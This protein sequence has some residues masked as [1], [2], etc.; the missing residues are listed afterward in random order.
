[1]CYQIIILLQTKIDNLTH[2][3]R[4]HFSQLHGSPSHL[5]ISIFY[6]WRTIIADC[7]ATK[8]AAMPYKIHFLKRVLSQPETWWAIT[9]LAIGTLFWLAVL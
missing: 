6:D 1:M 7:G 5:T 9:C 4:F 2:T 3:L 8:T